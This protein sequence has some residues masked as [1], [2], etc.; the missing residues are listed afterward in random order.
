MVLAPRSK[1]SFLVDRRRCPSVNLEDHDTYNPLPSLYK[2][3]KALHHYTW[4]SR[5]GML[6]MLVYFESIFVDELGHAC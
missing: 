4:S 3:G 2:P 5:H 1:E 6:D